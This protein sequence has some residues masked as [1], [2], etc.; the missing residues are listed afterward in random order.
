MKN[1]FNYLII[2]SCGL[3]FTACDNAERAAKDSQLTEAGQERADSLYREFIVVNDSLSYA[4][5]DMIKD[6]DEKLANMKRL[7]QE[8]SYT[9]NFNKQRH[10]SLLQRVDL[11]EDMRY[12]MES[13]ADSDKIDIYDAASGVL[14]R[15]IT[16]FAV[17]HPDYANYPLMEEL[18]AE[19]EQANERVLLHRIRYDQSA[20]AYNSFIQE[21]KGL[22]IDDEG[23]EA[24][25]KE[26]PLFELSN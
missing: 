14:S 15:D 8:V 13:M 7:L 5:Q 1:I 20:K 22:E 4:W 23:L 12:D 21:N 9:Q 18:I 10:D 6:D 26:K 24:R 16:L 25:W 19:I 3:I 17:N 2:M 11:L